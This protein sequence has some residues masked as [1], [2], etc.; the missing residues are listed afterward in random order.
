MAH[1]RPVFY[2]RISSTCGGNI[3]DV[4]DVSVLRPSV[5]S[6]GSGKGI[7]C[8]ICSVKVGQN[9][10]ILD[11][12]KFGYKAITWLADPQVLSLFSCFDDWAKSHDNRK[13]TNFF[14]KVFDSVP[15]E[16]PLFKLERQGCFSGFSNSSGCMQRVVLRRTCSSWSPLLSGIPSEQFSRTCFVY[17]I[18]KRCAQMTTRFTEKYPIYVAVISTNVLP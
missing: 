17:H 2:G 9:I 7:R 13:L 11:P 14:S 3:N 16:R 6:L 10:N 4:C 5:H 15:H 8:D 12:N 1:V 18:W